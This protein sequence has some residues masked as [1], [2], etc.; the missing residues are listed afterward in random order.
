MPIPAE[1]SLLLELPYIQP[2]QAQKHVT[3]NEALRILDVVVQLAVA[4]RSIADPPSGAPEGARYLV[5]PSGSGAWLGQGGRI[6]LREQG[7]WQFLA[8]VA[9][10]LALVLDEDR[11]LFFDGSDWRLPDMVPGMIDQLGIQTSA[12]A[13]NR[14]AVAAPASLFTHAGN[15]HQMKINKAAP[16][17][18]ASL[19]FQSGWSGRAEMGLA[20]SDDFAIRVSDDGTLWRD[21]VRIAAGSGQ[22]QLDHGL[23]VTGLITGSA[24]TQAADDATAGRVLKVG[25]SAGL[26]A[27]SPL[28]RVAL[29]GSADALAL[30]TG[31]GLSAPPPD[32]M[33]LRFRATAPNSGAATIA[34]DGGAAVE[35]RTLTGAA[36]PAGYIRTDCDTQAVMEGGVWVL[37]RAPE[38]GSNADG[39]YWRCATGVQHVWA[40]RTTD[41]DIAASAWAF[42]VPFSALHQTS[43]AAQA[44]TATSATTSAPTPTGC[45]F[46][47][48]DPSGARVQGVDVALAACG[49]WYG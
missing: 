19:V 34:L 43:A 42:P 10:W 13:T 3:H 21:G 2:A 28:M 41:S 49:L 6:A 17:D 35:C 26:L 24:V 44:E 12:D 22:V 7:A 27:A 18:T 45:G 14:L 40:L 39:R 15:D 11:L 47:A 16:P 33:R 48:W 5:P 31:A 30:T 1:T 23:Q 36:L 25:D 37:D 29:G 20:G 4:S 9:G 32:G 8:P 46:D 38:Y